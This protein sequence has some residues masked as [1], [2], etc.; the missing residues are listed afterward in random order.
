MSKAIEELSFKKFVLKD[1]ELHIIFFCFFFSCLF[2]MLFFSVNDN[3][4]Y[5]E[6][7]TNGL[8]IIVA[9]YSIFISADYA[10]HRHREIEL[11]QNFE[12]LFQE[13]SLIERNVSKIQE[14]LF[15]LKQKWVE[16][17]SDQWISPKKKIRTPNS[18]HSKFLYQFL[19]NNAYM[20]NQSRGYDRFII[21]YDG[22]QQIDYYRQI[23]QFYR[24]SMP[25]SEKSERIEDLIN[26]II[27]HLKIYNGQNPNI[28]FFENSKI[29]II[30]NNQLSTVFFENI[31]FCISYNAD[32]SQKSIAKLNQRWVLKNEIEY[33][34]LTWIQ[35]IDEKCS[36]IQTI[37]QDWKSAIMMNSP[38]IYPLK[39]FYI[40]TNTILDKKSLK[41]PGF[42]EKL[43]YLDILIL[44]TVFIDLFLITLCY[45][46]G[47][48]IP[49]IVTFIGF[50]QIIIPNPAYIW[51]YIT[52]FPIIL[53]ILCI[54]LNEENLKPS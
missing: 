33:Q 51:Y 13:I 54:I 46:I 26:V 34:T 43:E 39:D 30:N 42:L 31:D 7:I 50:D 16:L 29:Q 3:Q 48:I 47:A 40:F 25:C 52:S 2:L 49:E 36:Q 38:N 44:L 41:I 37:F 24:I 18:Y 15:F 4:L 35:F 20:D 17:T 14:Q 22:D 32:L 9:V 12:S 1:K 21:G 11:S 53:L 6:Y 10:I 28:Q 19:P 23:Y 5:R 45:A 27:N 8:S